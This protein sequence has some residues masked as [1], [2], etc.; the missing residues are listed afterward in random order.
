MEPLPC[1]VIVSYISSIPYASSTLFIQVVKHL[2]LEND[3]G[4]EFERKVR[5]TLKDNLPFIKMIVTY[6]GKE[7]KIPSVLVDTGSATTIFAADM[8]AQIGITP[9]P[10]DILHTLRGIGGTEVVFTR[11]VD[12]LRIGQY[13]IDH[14]EIEVGGMDYGFEMNGILGTDFLVQIGAIINLHQLNLQSPNSR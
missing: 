14:F 4:L 8:V 12:R 2:I 7:I 5:L 3:S 13:G 1:N 9:D 6:G 10:D 11:Q